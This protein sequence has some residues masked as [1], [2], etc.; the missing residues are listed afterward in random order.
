MVD[1]LWRFFETGESPVPCVA[2]FR[3]VHIHIS[4]LLKLL[5]HKWPAVYILP[6][7]YINV[8]LGAEELVLGVAQEEGHQHPQGSLPGDVV[9]MELR[10][11]QSV[12]RE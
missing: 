6:L 9:A 11:A 8:F 10:E 2:T 5:P 3:R 7:G 4:L 12:K 1:S